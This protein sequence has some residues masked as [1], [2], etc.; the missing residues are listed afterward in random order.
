MS[1]NLLLEGSIVAI[2][3][4]TKTKKNKKKEKE[5]DSQNL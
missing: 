1:N 2:S 4:Q 5:K 3:K